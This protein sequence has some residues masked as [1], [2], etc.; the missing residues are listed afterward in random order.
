MHP[1]PAEEVGNRDYSPVM[2]QLD[3][4]MVLL[5][6]MQV[7]ARAANNS[8]PVATPQPLLLASPQAKSA[9]LSTPSIS[10]SA[11]AAQKEAWLAGYSSGL[12]HAHAQALHHI[13][14]LGNIQTAVAAQGDSVEDLRSKYENLASQ[15]SFLQG[16]C[17]QA[18]TGIWKALGRNT[19]MIEERLQVEAALQSRVESL[20]ARL[21]VNCIELQQQQTQVAAAIQIA[22]HAWWR[23]LRLQLP[24]VPPHVLLQVLLGSAVADLLLRHSSVVMGS[25]FRFGRRM[26]RKINFLV[27][28]LSFLRLFFYA[29]HVALPALNNV[30]LFLRTISRPFAAINTAAERGEAVCM[31]TRFCP[32]S[33]NFSPAVRDM[34]AEFGS[35]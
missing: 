22:K 21:A 1:D 16:T 13:E 12:A 32:D 4:T 5:K 6:S 3:E 27:A 35:D 9:L 24:Q 7:A 17:T 31:F 28:I 19:N 14:E 34:V 10:F 15:L 20:E 26:M 30:L 29:S 2:D 33:P 25:R 18:F 8:T 11:H 23:H